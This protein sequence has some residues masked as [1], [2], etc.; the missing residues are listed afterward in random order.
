MY[1][2]CVF[3][4]SVVIFNLYYYD[5]MVNSM[6]SRTSKGVKKKK[7]TTADQHGQLDIFIPQSHKYKYL[8]S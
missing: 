3:V 8:N 1:I 6:K 5:D 2:W 4:N 7:K